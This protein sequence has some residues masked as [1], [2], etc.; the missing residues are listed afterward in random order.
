MTPQDTVLTG[1]TFQQ[2]VESSLDAI[3]LINEA[4]KII[5]ANN[6]A[7]T[8]F[9]YSKAEF[10]GQNFELLMPEHHNLV[11]A[12]FGA[13]FSGGNAIHASIGDNEL[14][15][16]KKDGT[17]FATE[18][19]INPIVTGD[20]T[21]LQATIT[22]ITERT[23][24]EATIKQQLTE[25]QRAGNYLEQL[26]YISA[27]D[28]KSPILTLGD[29]TDM[30]L[31]SKD[32]KPDVVQMLQMQKKLIIQM[33]KTNKGINDIL[34]LR[35]GL[36]ARENAD[37]GQMALG[38]I[39]GNV[40]DTLR[41]DIETTGATLEVN[42]NGLSEVQFPYFYLQSAFYNLIANAIKYRHPDRKPVIVFEAKNMG[43][44]TF[45]FIVTD[46]G[47]GFDMASNKNNLFGIFKR[48]H[49]KIDGTGLGLHIVKSIID[50][51]NGEVV[52]SSEVDKGT[53]FD[54]ILKNPILA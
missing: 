14:R 5:Y 13:A 9:G 39:L 34:K 50:A 36:L 43:A 49:P 15:A 6:K 12:Q 20:G 29:L 35:Q 10:K 31:S 3:V 2:I 53:T 26:A 32:I 41:A 51:Y 19:W 16:V 4:G 30:L 28:I 47:S 24:K 33:Q 48:F 44:Q 40:S 8:M 38:A 27:H 17:E 46:N 21:L 42:L 45:R 11:Q 37:S 7:E 25:L 22:D 18:M 23:E 1:F 52:V 54:I